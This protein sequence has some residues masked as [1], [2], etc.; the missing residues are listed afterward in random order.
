M[1]VDSPNQQTE[2][3]EAGLLGTGIKRGNRERQEGLGGVMGGRC[4]R[5]Q[6]LGDDGRAGKAE[7]KRREKERCGDTSEG[8][9]WEEG[10]GLQRYTVFLGETIITMSNGSSHRPLPE[11]STVISRTFLLPLPHVRG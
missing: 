11:P 7:E 10:A 9:E 4:G 6:Q 5:G 3:K 8:E 1:T 2:K